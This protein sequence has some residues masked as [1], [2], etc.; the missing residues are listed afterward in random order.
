MTMDSF[1]SVSYTHLLGR[2]APV[3]GLAA[4]DIALPDNGAV[5]AVEARVLLGEIHVNVAGAEVAAALVGG[6]GLSLIHI[7]IRP[8]FEDI[9]RQYLEPLRLQKR[10]VGAAQNERIDVAAA[11]QMCIRDRA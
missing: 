8:E 10:I 5:L 1:P 4:D 3:G 7:Y 11:Q 9:A 2:V 6:L